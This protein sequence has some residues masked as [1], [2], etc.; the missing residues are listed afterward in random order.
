M[1][2]R[3]GA[4]KVNGNVYKDAI[5][6]Y[7]PEQKTIN[8]IEWDWSKTNFH[9]KP[10]YSK[11]AINKL[12]SGIGENIVNSHIIFSLGMNSAIQYNTN[13]QNSLF[14]FLQTK[15]ADTKNRNNSQVVKLSTKSQ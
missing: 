12:L 10:G 14:D 2:V 11:N 15:L 7:D 1:D 5:V 8:S 13:E 4:V 6:T 9:H 3:W